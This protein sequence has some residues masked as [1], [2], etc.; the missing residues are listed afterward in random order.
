MRTSFHS[1]THPA[2]SVD[3]CFCFLVFLDKGTCIHQACYH[4]AESGSQTVKC[5]K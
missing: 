2:S 3:W 5:L 1:G 4:Q